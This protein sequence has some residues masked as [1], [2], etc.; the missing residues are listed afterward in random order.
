MKK[1]IAAA[2]L[3][4]STAA[5]AQNQVVEFLRP[6]P[7]T[8]GIALSKWVFKDQKK[9]FYVEV[10]AQADNLESAR[11]SAFRMAVERAVGVVVSSEK[12]VQNYQLQRNE[13][14]T[15]ASGY[16]ED[17]QLVQQQTVN[18]QTQVQMKVWVSY[19]ALSNRLLNISRTAGTVEGDRIS[20]QIRSVQQE[21]A[22]A[23]RLLSTVLA[24][25]P[26]RAFNVT[27]EPTRV[28]MN[29]QRQGELQIP[30]VVSWNAHYIKSINEAVQLINQKAN[31]KGWF[32]RCV[33]NS[34][35][36]IAGEGASF[37]D[38]TMAYDLMHREMVISRPQLQISIQDQSGKVQFRQC[39]S[40][41]ELDYTSYAP[42]HFVE[43]GGYKAMINAG[44][45][46]RFTATIDLTT[47]PTRMLDRVEVLI[48]RSR[49]C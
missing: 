36:S 11:E 23:D 45:S 38:D 18:N 9:I 19:S 2:A 22:S 47:L 13:I 14:I 6:S 35:I 4:L 49:Q 3:I 30:F 33:S 15:Y 37:F 10:T 20:E 25:Y 46:K 42:V 1:L 7:W 40:A 16:V 32:S 39:M 12:E 27:L 29:S 41:P 48:V 28:T 21:R 8:I 34:T 24:D 31:C 26:R 17:Y 44:Y 43:L 5:L